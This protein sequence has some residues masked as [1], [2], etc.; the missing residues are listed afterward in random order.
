MA[1]PRKHPRRWYRATQSFAF[2]DQETGRH[3]QFRS[4]D[5]LPEGKLLDKCRMYF[6]PLDEDVPEEVKE[7]GRAT[8]DPRVEAAADSREGSSGGQGAR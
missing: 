7:D 4:G 2:V 5:Q 6:E 1:R 8:S 3:H